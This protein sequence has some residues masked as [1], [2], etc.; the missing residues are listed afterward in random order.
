MK[1]IISIDIILLTLKQQSN[2]KQDS[3]QSVM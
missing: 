2:P 3:V 1:L